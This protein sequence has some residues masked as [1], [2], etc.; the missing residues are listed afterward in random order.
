M[1]HLKDKHQKDKQINII[2]SENLPNNERVRRKLEEKKKKEA[3]EERQNKLEQQKQQEDELMHEEMKKQNEEAQR[4]HME[5]QKNMELDVRKALQQIKNGE[6]NIN[7]ILKQV[8]R[9]TSQTDLSFASL[10]INDWDFHGLMVILPDNQ[11]LLSLNLSRKNLNND[12]AKQISEVLKKN[13][14]L[15]RLELEG[16]QFGSESCLHFSEAIKANKSLKYLDLENNLLTDNGT[17]TNGIES[18]CKSLEENTSLL[19]LNISNN[20]LNDVCSQRIIGMLRKNNTLIHLEIF[21]NENYSI[22]KERVQN[23]SKFFLNG[24]SIEHV[25][26]IRTLINENREKDSKWRLKEWKERKNVNFEEV[27]TMNLNQ[28]L[29]KAKEECLKRNEVKCEIFDVYKEKFDLILK[30][31][32]EEFQK[33][34]EGFYVETKLRLDKKPKKGRSV[35]KKK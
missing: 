9:N 7:E 10:E 21:N 19:S 35:S 18:L 5:E 13:K 29:M 15:R 34:V 1:E 17:N 33:K 20:S 14:R 3:E 25:N 27:E 12:K 30:R 24:P 31:S 8:Y 26:Q 23:E 22:H 11:S 16:N 32:E 4:K 6:G 28:D 2:F